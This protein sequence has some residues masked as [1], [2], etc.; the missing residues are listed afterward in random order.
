MK[1]DF[2]NLFANAAI[3]PTAVLML[4]VALFWT[5]SSHAQELKLRPELKSQFEQLN[6][7]CID[8]HADRADNGD[9]AIDDVDPSSESWNP[10]AVK[11]AL[12]VIQFHEMP[13]RD[14][15]QLPPASVDEI[16]A[17]LQQSLSGTV[18]TGKVSLRRLNRIEYENTIRDL[19]RTSSAVFSNPDRLVINDFYFKPSSR[20]MPRHV[21]AY[22]HFAAA[23]KSADAI[24]GVP[25]L[26]ID[27]PAEYGFNNQAD[28]LSFS[29]VLVER[30]FDIAKALLDSPDFPRMSSIW[31]ALF[32]FPK[33]AT[34]KESQ[35]LANTRIEF[36]LPRAFRRPVSPREI[37]RYQKLFASELASNDDPLAAMK[38]TVSTVLVST[39]FLFRTDLVPNPDADESLRNYAL[40]SRLSYFI[41]ASMPDDELLQA[42][43]EHQLSDPQL[44]EKQVSRM[45]LDRKAKSLA[46]DFGMQWLKVRKIASAAPEKSLFGDFYR[47]RDN[48]IWASMQIEQMLLFETIMVENRSILD[49][50]DAD[51]AYLNN[52]LMRW[53]SPSSFEPIGFTPEHENFE[54]FFRV[55]LTSRVRGG[56]LTSGAMLASTSATTRTSPVYR[57]AWIAE[58]IFNHPPPPPPDNIPELEAAIV[59]IGKT[60]DVRSMLAEHRKN[61]A[62]A[63]CHDR[64]D[65][66][67][68]AFEHYDAVGRKRGK[69]TD[70]QKVDSA[71]ELFGIEFTTA[72]QFKLVLVEKHSEKFVRAFTEHVMKYALSRSLDY[73][74]EV[75]LVSMTKQVVEKRNRFADVIRAVALSPP[76]LQYE[77]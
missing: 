39:H 51:F 6:T 16:T 48:P 64:I 69:Y 72:P 15:E 71:G 49:F 47:R 1:Y 14:A 38:T 19:F 17:W 60:K 53:Y 57:G 59:E 76:F 43:K 45:L 75:H 8:C 65:P 62:C 30:Y 66:L 73:S 77:E 5:G 42:A 52:D 12:D 21:L 68:L 70:G 33:D 58:V 28:A 36:F 74:D 41:W 29:P 61:T 34:A 18:T 31:S 7:H 13:P 35:S 9:F 46:T 3:T 37:E 20:R 22:S 25:T 50:I 55:K 40:A 11:R 54:D 24:E 67:G 44:V 26:P 27:A 10:E 23:Q 56:V 63:S 4:V 32:V 2:Q